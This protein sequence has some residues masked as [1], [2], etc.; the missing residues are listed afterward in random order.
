MKYKDAFDAYLQEIRSPYKAIVA[1]S[2]K[3]KHYNTGEEMSEADMNKF[4]DDDNDIPCQFRKQEYRFLI[5]A[6]KFKPVFDQ[7]LL[8]TMYVDKQLSSVAA[9][10][11]LSAQ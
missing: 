3:K 9:V 11:T 4:P 8:H 1:F 10:Q 6:E 7:P 5:V 2:G